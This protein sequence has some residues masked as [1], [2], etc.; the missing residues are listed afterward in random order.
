MSRR[1]NGQLSNGQG[2]CRRI[3][4]A[5]GSADPAHSTMLIRKWN[6]SNV[7][8]GRRPSKSTRSWLLRLLTKEGANYDRNCIKQLH[9]RMGLAEDLKSRSSGPDLTKTARTIV[10]RVDSADDDGVEKLRLNPLSHFR[11]IDHSGVNSETETVLPGQPRPFGR[12][13]VLVSCESRHDLKSLADQFRAVAEPLSTGYIQR[14]S[15]IPPY[16]VLRRTPPWR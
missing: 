1:R 10:P 7:A 6:W 11:M 13:L 15:K 2:P 14:P 16:H 8:N 4:R 12:R 9:E 3:I 5:G